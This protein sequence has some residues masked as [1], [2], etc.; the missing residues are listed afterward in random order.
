[1][2]PPARPPST[3]GRTKDIWGERTPFAPGTDWPERADAHLTREPERWVTSA[4]VLCSNGCGLDIGVAEGRIVGVRGRTGDRVNHGR[5]GPKGLYGWQA[6]NSPD[7]LTRPLVRRDGAL[8]ETG[9]DEAMDL[10]VAGAQRVLEEHGPLAMGFYTSGQLFL[11]D[12]Y[13]QAV[14]AR[15]GIGTPHLDGNTRLCTSTAEWALIESFG[16]D[17]NPGSY[18][19]VD[20]ADTLFL[21]GHN[22]AETQTVL[23]ARML[24][25]LHGPDRPRLVVADPRRTPAAELADVHLPVRPGTNVMLLNAL[26]HEIIRTD[27]VDRAWVEAHT[28]GFDELAAV[29][30]GYPPERAAGVCGVPADGIRAAAELLGAAERLVSTVLQGV[31]QSHQAT[32]AAVQVNN[33]HLL[34]GMIGRPGRTVFQMNGQ[35]TAQNT[36]ETGANGLFPA[37]LNWQNDEHVERLARHWHVDPMRIPHWAPPTHAMKML[38]Y[39]EQGSLRWLWITGTNPAVSW[40]ELGRVRSVL[41]KEGLFLVVSD[42]FRTE[43]TDLADVVLPAALWGEKAGTFTNADRTVHYSGKAVDP[44]G[45]ARADFEALLAFARAMG[46]LDDE[47]EPLPRWS[48]PEEAFDD[49]RALTRGALCDYSGLSHELLRRDGGVQWPRPEHADASTERLYGDGRFRT[50]ASECQSYGHDLL[51]G[52]LNEADEYAAHDPAGRAIIK[53]AEYLPPHDVLDDEHPLRLTTGRTVHHWHTRTKTARAPELQAAA[54]DMWIEMF[55]DDA[56]AR[57]IAD[58]DMVQVVSRHGLVQAT[59]RLDGTR[60]GVVFAPFHYGYFDVDDASGEGD[61]EG[62]RAANEATPTDWDPVSKQPVYK[63]TAVEVVPLGGDEERR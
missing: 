30:K 11:E 25:R 38:R 23:W 3:A 4:C 57:D 59:V 34:R 45:E 6:G 46:L 27:R 39:I 2:R 61:A 19:D 54:P 26:L 28:V 48:T 12:Y 31:Y 62:T 63:V 52:A 14:I 10:V 58:G 56:A 9:W 33:L 35:P 60:R 50:G 5:L 24:D 29:V 36:R 55:P 42:A 43:T 7:R 53:A 17:G 40:P 51:T 22:V 1:M 21:A 37:F 47:G 15:A 16:S 44:P 41:E 32:A 20:H 8:V 49:F 18:T 13:L